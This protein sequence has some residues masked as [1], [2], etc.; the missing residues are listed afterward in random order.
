MDRTVKTYLKGTPGERRKIH[1]VGYDM[2]IEYTLSVREFGELRKLDLNGMGFDISEEGMGLYT[3]YRL[4]PGHVL[5]IR[6]GAGSRRSA[7]VRWA[8]EIDGRFRIGLL[9]YK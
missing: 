4:E 6:D 3:D 9:F 2:P 8:A 1:R 5:N 7:V